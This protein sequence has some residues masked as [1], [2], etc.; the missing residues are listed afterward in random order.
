MPALS[1]FSPSLSEGLKH[2]I[3]DKVA[4][5][6]LQ[7]TAVLGRSCSKQIRVYVH[8]RT[9]SRLTPAERARGL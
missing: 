4:R 7:I 3:Q 8:K 1:L 9:R 6:R 2:A 5:Y